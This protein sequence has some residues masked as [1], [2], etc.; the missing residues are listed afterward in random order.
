[1][2]DEIVVKIKPDT[3]FFGF[4]HFTVSLFNAIQSQGNTPLARKFSNI[5]SHSFDKLFIHSRPS[6]DNSQEAQA[7]LPPGTH[8]IPLS[9]SEVR[10]VLEMSF[11]INACLVSEDEEELS[12][13]VKMSFTGL[14]DNWMMMYIQNTQKYFDTFEEHYKNNESFK[15]MLDKI[16]N[17]NN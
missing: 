10:S 12:E 8:S 14:P 11:N 5:R 2:P 13:V 7:S 1:M 15:A 3:P 16:A 4:C 17:T 9:K 6:D